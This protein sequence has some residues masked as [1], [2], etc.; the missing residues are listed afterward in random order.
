MPAVDLLEQARFDQE[1]DVPGDGLAACPQHVG[2][3]G[4]A[5]DAEGLVERPVSP[6]ALRPPPFVRGPASRTARVLP[7]AVW[8]KGS[9]IASSNDHSGVCCFARSS[10][11]GYWSH[12]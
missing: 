12:S 7:G 11:E 5:G 9:V 1:S 10:V 3:L 2:Q 6:N 8:R 4:M